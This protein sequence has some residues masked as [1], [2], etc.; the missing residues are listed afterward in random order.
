MH[1]IR[2]GLREQIQKEILHWFDFQGFHNFEIILFD[3]GYPFAILIISSG[4]YI[5]RKECRAINDKACKLVRT[6]TGQSNVQRWFGWACLW[7]IKGHTHAPHYQSKNRKL[8]LVAKDQGGIS[9][10]NKLLET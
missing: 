1:G 3:F 10:Q 9:Y 2:T 7:K 8:Q 5:V 6:N 4:L